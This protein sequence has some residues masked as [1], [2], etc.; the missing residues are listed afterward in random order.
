M[1]KMSFASPSLDNGVRLAYILLL[2]K[3]KFCKFFFA[4]LFIFPSFF[5]FPRPIRADVILPPLNPTNYPA[6]FEKQCQPGEKEVICRVEH[7]K[8]QQ[9]YLYDEC[10]LFKNNPHYYFL[11]SAFDSSKYCLRAGGKEVGQAE[12]ER[13]R[14]SAIQKYM[15][16]IAKGKKDERLFV[17][18][19]AGT[20]LVLLYVIRRTN[21]G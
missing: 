9:E 8:A 7:N 19:V 15:A 11:A 10:H 21:V 14:L 1:V 6:F 20:A 4:S 3:M 12:I 16:E 2:G 17:F 13:Y 18:S 5:I